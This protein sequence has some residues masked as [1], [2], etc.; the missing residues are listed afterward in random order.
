MVFRSIKGR[1]E[2]RAQEY[3]S[4]QAKGTSLSKSISRFLVQEFG[5]IGEDFYQE[6]IYD[7]SKKQ[8]II[9]IKNRVYANELQLRLNKLTEFLKD[10]N[11][12]VTQIKIRI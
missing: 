12:E 2:K 1:L 6:I 4:L 7:P 5:S 9:E 8:V 10:L 3:Q 11:L